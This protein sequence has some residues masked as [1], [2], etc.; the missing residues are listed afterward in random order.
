MLLFIR[1]KALKF[2]CLPEK[3]SAFGRKTE[4]EF[5]SLSD[6]PQK[7]FSEP[8]KKAGFQRGMLLRSSCRI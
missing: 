7:N 4:N 1:Q 6:A 3:F 8:R 2:P 5:V